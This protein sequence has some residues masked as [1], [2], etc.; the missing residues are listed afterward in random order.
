M[1]RGSIFCLVAS[2]LYLFSGT[3]PGAYC[4]VLITFLAIFTAFLLQSYLQRSFGAT[5]LCMLLTMLLYELVVFGIAL[6]LQLT[7]FARLGAACLTGL[8][9]VFAAAVLYPVV[10]AIG[11]IGG[12]TWK[13]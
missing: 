5:M 8:Y 2:L 4:V 1:E 13:E 3:A 9:S 10:Q 7:V 11:T 6:F 12:E